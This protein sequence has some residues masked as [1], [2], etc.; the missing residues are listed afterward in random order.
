M[1]VF[2]DSLYLTPHID[3]M[4][5]FDVFFKFLV[6][7]Y[8]IYIS[9]LITERQTY[10]MEINNSGKALTK[11]K[12]KAEQNAFKRLQGQFSS[13]EQLE[14]I[15]QHILRNEKRKVFFNKVKFFIQLRKITIWLLKKKVYC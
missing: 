4:H 5:N 6:N 8:S 7:S 10:L 11:L 15:D 12:E 13:P 2:N 1:Q 14:Q 3:Y 9:L